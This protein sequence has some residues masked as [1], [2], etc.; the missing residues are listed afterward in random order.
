M[1]QFEEIKITVEA[2]EKTSATQ[3]SYWNILSVVSLALIAASSSME[4]TLYLIV[5]S[6]ILFS[7][8]NLYAIR[9]LQNEMLALKSHAL[10]LIESTS[11]SPKVY[12]IILKSKKIITLSHVTLYHFSI[13]LLVCLIISITKIV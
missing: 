6:Y 9:T 3:V 8:S 4:I 11:T 1:N 10:E 12:S 5:P 7:I 13:Q 2:F